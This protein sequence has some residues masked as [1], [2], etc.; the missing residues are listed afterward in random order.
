MSEAH[1]DNYTQYDP[2]K[3]K[4]NGMIYSFTGLRG[5]AKKLYTDIA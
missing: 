2:D 1:A 3:F 4:T 5:D